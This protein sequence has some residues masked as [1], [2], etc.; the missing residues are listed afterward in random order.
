VNV[1][2]VR[3]ESRERIL[4]GIV[5]PTGSGKSTLAVSLARAFDGEIVSCDAM[6]VY[7]YLDVGT[8]K[9]TE[10]ERGDIPHHLLD[11]VNPDEEFSAADYVRSAAPTIRNL[12]SRGKLPIVVGGTGL[13][14]RALMRGLFEGPGRRPQLR[15]RLSNI[16]SHRGPH[17]LHRMLARLDSDSAERIHP[18]D[19]VRVVRALE[20]TFASRTTMSEM[21]RRRRSPLEGWRFV[22]V[23]LT[24]PREQLT[25]RIGERVKRMLAAGF[26]EEVR[27][28]LDAYG[29]HVPAFKAIGYKELARFLSGEL[30]L[31]EAERLTV[32]TTTQYAK[33]QMTWFRHEDG[34]RWFAGWGDDPELERKVGQHIRTELGMVC[35]VGEEKIYA[36]TAP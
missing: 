25:Q 29:A 11:V 35:P 10:E 3:L 9:I 28:L 21:M 1:S 6:Q 2:E 26:V 27:R 13:Y 18:N 12:G 4:V 22:L 23:G 34:V 30:S 36:K 8:G 33:R 7:R 20:V 16:A 17:F 31:A 19:L 15:A 24:P 5:G 14:L 32:K